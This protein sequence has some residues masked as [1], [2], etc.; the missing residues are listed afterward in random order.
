[1]TGS[2]TDITTPARGVSDPEVAVV[3]DWWTANARAL[4]WRSSRDVYAVWVSEV[5]SAQTTVNRAAEA[6]VRWMERWPTVE[7]LA[8]ASLA[9]VL[10]QWQG[11]GY[12]RRARD[13][14]RSGS[15]HHRVGLARGPVR[16]ARGGALHRRRG[17][18][19][20]ARGAGAAVDL[21]VRRVLRRR[22][23]GHVDISG[24]PWR[25]GQALMEFGQRVCTA[26]PDCS[27]CPV[28]DGCGGPEAGDRDAEPAR[29]QKPFAGSVRQR[30]GRLLRRVLEEGTVRVPAGEAE[31][32]AALADDG[33]AVL[34][35]GWLRPPP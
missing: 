25:A 6:W 5:M 23:D 2:L 3:L 13:L 7:A 18:L 31:I 16:P 11:L 20:R 33:L 24:D 22:L 27:A 12:P 32:A 34:D 19:L 30:R 14:H 10:G 15:D 1:M 26:R 28:R 35:G 29:R 8:A 17:A 21:N 4:P 9:D